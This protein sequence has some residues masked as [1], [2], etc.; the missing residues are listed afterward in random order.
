MSTESRKKIS[1][2]S[3]AGEPEMRKKNS[4]SHKGQIPWN[5]GKTAEND[6]RIA[7]YFAGENAPL[8]GKRGKQH[9]SFGKPRPDTAERDRQRK[10]ELHPNFGKHWTDE[11]IEHLRQERMK[12]KSTGDNNNLELRVFAE[13]RKRLIPF[14]THKA[15]V[16]IPDA[17]IW[18]NICVM[19]DGTRYHADPDIRQAEDI[20]WKEHVDK[21]GQLR[22]EIR[23]K[24]IWER[25]AKKTLA[26][27]SQGNIVLRLKE[28][29]I[30]K[31][32]ISVIDQVEK[33][34]DPAIKEFVSY[35]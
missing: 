7:M 29:A 5:K 14:E 16:G 22:P 21:D 4:E 15:M 17:F 11:E 3:R 20:I 23:A 30:N 34:V 13:L 33:Y 35:P 1:Q 26:M 9:P 31:D 2:N 18:P 10:G 24:H 8:F 28:R 25:D 19:V 27:E 6:E 12:Q 32:L